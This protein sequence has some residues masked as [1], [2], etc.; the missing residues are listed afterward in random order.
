MTI[1]IRR[2]TTRTRPDATALPP[3]GGVAAT[4]APAS[5]EV[6]PR[7]LRVGDGYAATLVVTGYPAEV[8]PAWL[9]PLLSWPGRLDLALHIDPIPAPVAASRLRNQRARFESSRRADEQ[10]GKLTDPYV[11][12]AAD[13]A[14]DLAE[15]LAR[16]AAKLFRVGLYLTV[17]AR[18]EPELLDACAQVKAAAA[19]TLIEVQPATWR[20]LPGWTTTLPLATDSLQMRRTMDTQALAA[21]FPLASADLPAPLPGDPATTGGVLYGVNP[22]SQGIVWW[23]RW[24]QENH[25]S[26]V[27]ARSGAGKSYFVKLDVLR[28]LYQG[29][30]VAVV[31]PEDE[32][33]RLAD[34][35]GGTIVRLGAP[36]VKINPLDLPAGD[37]RPD[38]LTR[39]G[40]FLH[41]LISVLVGQL[42]PPAE[43]AALDRAILAVYRQAGITADPATHHRPA[44]L[45]KDLA[46]TL[47]ADDAAAAHELAARLAPWVAGSYSD[48]FDSPTTTRP[49]GHLVV[50]SLRHLP[51][52]L[53]T[54]GTLLALDEIWR[55]VDLPRQYRTSS[56]PEARRLV[57]V[58]EAWLLMRDGEGARFLFKMSKAGR[59]RNAGLS[60]ITQDVAD[61]LG[62]DLGQAV[63]SNAATQVLLKQAPQAIDQ[64]ADAFGLTAGER[65]MLL[66]AR[67]G[68]GL[69]ISGTNRTAFESISSQAEHLLATTKPSDLADLDSD[70]GEDEL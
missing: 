32:Y 64:V 2:P 34:A 11:E 67:V 68:H 50:W 43:R 37:I 47:R 33:L 4:V 49:D 42:P 10:K 31:D 48:L 55:Q 45:L 30:Q 9:E 66:S 46:A 63:V 27:L 39:R 18:T 17:H 59:K 13:D 5:V 12:A 58:D 29:V 61:V 15:R 40:L 51:D 70:D 26:V 57:V 1:R 16:G 21:A 53:R 60:V 65:R 36:G 20:H 38:V 25:N 69:L 7:F 8:G 62:T 41:T 35:V 44:P 56:S 22:D 19:S 6:T 54:V 24:A 28:N 23:D 3:A 14:A 52:E